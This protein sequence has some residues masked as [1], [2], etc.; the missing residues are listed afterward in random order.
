MGEGEG[1]P[2]ADGSGCGG[3][4]GPECP[5]DEG[6]DCEQIKCAEGEVC[7]PASGRCV[8]C[9]GNA[10]C[11]ADKPTCLN[12]TGRCGCISSAECGA[13]RR[14]DRGT[15]SCVR[16]MDGSRCVDDDDCPTRH[17]GPEAVCVFCLIDEHCDVQRG[18]V[19]NEVY[20][21]GRPVPCGQGGDHCPLGGVCDP[22]TGQCV[23]QGCEGEGEGEGESG[24]G[25]P[26]GG[27]CP[28]C[29]EDAECGQ[30]RFC[31]WGGR[32]CL[33]ADRAAICEPC[34]DDSQCLR[35]N[36][37]SGSCVERRAGGAR[38]ERFC[39]QDCEAD[40]DCPR[41][42]E[43]SPIAL[44][45]SSC[46]P[47]RLEAE[48]GQAGVSCAALV[49]VGKRCASDDD[50]GLGGEGFCWEQACAYGCEE[51]GEARRLCVQGFMCQPVPAEVHAWGGAC[52]RT[53][54]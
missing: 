13:L 14:C 46:L 9:I 38:L 44:G 10:D 22:A 29:E 17:C 54:D 24:G 49:E 53:E 11:T 40:R 12:L 15:E 36:E 37:P 20:E 6:V 31:D 47:T 18:E 4:S 21:C 8:Q 51:T 19:C 28:G 50:C 3:A 48:A 1:Q 39:G 35:P 52:V 7:H 25:G 27:Q 32:V 42:Y 45:V 33:D 2:G 5:P 34:G 30:G 26:Q 43:C 23:P 41:G 16:E